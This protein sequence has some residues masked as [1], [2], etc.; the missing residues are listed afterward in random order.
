MPSYVTSR[1]A[2]PVLQAEREAISLRYG[3]VNARLARMMDLRQIVPFDAFLIAGLSEFGLGGEWKLILASDLPIEFL[4]PFIDEGLY[5]HDP[6]ICGVSET[7]NW[8]EVDMDEAAHSGSDA[9]K[10]IHLLEHRHGIKGRVAL[11]IF[12]NGKRIASAMFARSVP[13]DARERFLLEMGVRVG[14]EELA[15]PFIQAMN[16]HLGLSKAEVVCLEDFSRG[17]ELPE[18]ELRTGYATNT[19]YSAVK[20]AM[21]KLGARNRTHAMAELLRR[22]IIT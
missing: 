22:K 21:R 10:R 17:F 14:Q 3:H 12:S 2:T 9:V 6:V 20:A 8:S 16:Q 5:G 4:R 18:I 1:T 15:R 7:A 19:I 13:F 11:G